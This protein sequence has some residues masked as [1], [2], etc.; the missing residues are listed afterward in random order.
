MNFMIKIQF[1]HQVPSTNISNIAYYIFCYYEFPFITL[2]LLSII[3]QGQNL[4][5][6]FLFKLFYSSVTF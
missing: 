5:I 1:T 2:I 6:N 3:V 4:H